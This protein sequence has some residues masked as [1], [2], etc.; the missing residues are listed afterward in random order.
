MT[1]QNTITLKGEECLGS[2]VKFYVYG[3]NYITVA[4]TNQRTRIDQPI[5]LLL[6]FC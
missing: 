2:I 5:N 1:S 3:E 4:Q 6:T